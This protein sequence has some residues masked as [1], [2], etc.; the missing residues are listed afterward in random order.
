V[1]LQCIAASPFIAVKGVTF[2][3]NCA[4]LRAHS[5]ALLACTRTPYGCTQAFCQ[6]A[7]DAFTYNAS[8]PGADSI[9]ALQPGLLNC[10]SQ[11]RSGSCAETCS[12]TPPPTMPLTF[13]PTTLRPVAP[14]VSRSPTS[15]A[16]S[17]AP[18]NTV[19]LATAR[20][21]SAPTPHPT[22][23][24]PQITS[25]VW[26]VLFSGL[27]L[28]FDRATNM[29][30]VMA[31]SSFMLFPNDTCTDITATLASLVQTPAQTVAPNCYRVCTW[32]SSSTLIVNLYGYST[33]T[34]TGVVILGVNGAAIKTQDGFSLAMNAVL[35]PYGPVGNVTNPSVYISG[36]SVLG[37]CSPAVVLAAHLSGMA[38]RQNGR[39]QW[40][41]DG[42]QVFDSSEG[43]S[44]EQFL[45]Q[46]VSSVSLATHM[47]QISVTNW[48]GGVG[49]SPAFTVTWEDNA[50]AA[51]V[52][53]GGGAVT[54]T[55]GAITVSSIVN[56]PPACPAAFGVVASAVT[57]TYQWY[58]YDADYNF[59][60][61]A[62]GAV[63]GQTYSTI[64]VARGALQ[65]GT[66]SFLLSIGSPVSPAIQG[67]A[68]TQVTVPVLPLVAVIKGGSALATQSSQE[69][70]LDASQS[71]DPN[72]FI[73]ACSLQTGLYAGGTT[74]VGFQW[75]CVDSIGNVLGLAQPNAAV[76]V[77]ASNTLL[78]DDSPYSCYVF[79]TPGLV[80]TPASASVQSSAVSIT[81]LPPPPCPAAPV[82][83][84]ILPAQLP[85]VSQLVL[86]TTTNAT[87]LGTATLQWT[88]DQ[89]VGAVLQ[90]LQ[91]TFA[92]TTLPFIFIDATKMLVGTQYTF[93]LTATTLCSAGA[94]RAV[95]FASVSFLINPGPQGGA[96]VVTPGSGV[97]SSPFTLAASG[98][99]DTALPLQ[100]AFEVLVSGSLASGT[101]TSLSAFSLSASLSTYLAA[102]ADGANMTV[103]VIV[104]DG[105]G[106][107]TPRGSVLALVEVLPPPVVPTPQNISDALS[108]L[109]TSGANADSQANAIA[110]FADAVSASS[111]AT[112]AA[113][114][115]STLLTSLAAATNATVA[116]GTATPLQLS[117]Q[118]SSLLAV[119]NS[120]S[121]TKN[122]DSTFLS[123]AGSLVDTLLAQTLKT[124]QGQTQGADD[125]LAQALVPQ[126][127]VDASLSSLE[128]YMQQALARLSDAIANPSRRRRR[129]LDSDESTYDTVLSSLVSVLGISLT[130]DISG[131]PAQV[132]TLPSYS[133]AMARTSAAD[134][135]VLLSA[136]AL[137]MPDD[138]SA[139]VNVT[140]PQ[141]MLDSASGGGVDSTTADV[142]AV[143]FAS[144]LRELAGPTDPAV[145]VD[146]FLT[147]D[148]FATG[149]SAPLV[150]I[151][152][153]NPVRVAFPLSFARAPAAGQGL[154]CGFFDTSAS[155]WSTAGCT[156]QASQLPA[157]ASDKSGS[158]TCACTHLSD[159]AFWTYVLPTSAPSTTVAPS[160]LPTS[161]VCSGLGCAP[162]APTPTKDASAAMA[163]SADSL[164]RAI[165][166]IVVVVVV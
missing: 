123:S 148:V 101:F 147:L 154:V 106:S 155:A 163:W 88:V 34:V 56:L 160:T 59:P 57:F 60:S 124:I 23:V 37:I 126:G 159:I 111:N 86:R 91:T 158:V 127:L 18:S 53:S 98:F 43:V 151:D 1:Y 71:C 95:T 153:A 121:A 63:Q 103:V 66:Y 81:V 41:T 152:L 125:P 94:Q 150:L 76:L 73:P 115:Q 28:T 33:L 72:V 27:E 26:N 142:L 65:P 93:T 64:A 5:D 54:A 8:A 42:V 15:L 146:S 16:P 138:A 48:L 40:F 109:S 36:P 162:T 137:P 136:L 50:V 70:T 46:T 22:S 85:P 87:A 13:A 47:Y 78:A 6:P 105:I 29:A 129:H 24:A 122:N 118:V 10:P 51:V 83:L 116:S 12:G 11:F 61:F 92:P 68:S 149:S 90:S 21:S 74:N 39:V 69:V 7:C 80:S 32:Q 164:I 9:S 157:S 165:T 62:P 17:A 132:A 75:E 112:A 55:G 99:S 120:A 49:L 131:S 31:C 89:P 161:P 113:E 145:V 110:S 133:T 58:I 139:T 30:G 114:A 2:L 107:T 144:N 79:L 135:G 140:L 100:Y 35:V 84:G 82:A 67:Y 19:P 3:E 134:V 166:V 20:P 25:A 45:T 119:L 96:L 156:V 97:S 14:P 128:S 77:I 130:G 38:G 108:S 104:K 141:G 4:N 117:V 44:V 102:G 143:Y 52:L